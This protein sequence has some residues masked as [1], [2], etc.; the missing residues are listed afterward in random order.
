MVVLLEKLEIYLKEHLNL[1]EYV[2]DIKAYSIDFNRCLQKMNDW[3][4]IDNNPF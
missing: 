3:I 1:N 4:S 2:K